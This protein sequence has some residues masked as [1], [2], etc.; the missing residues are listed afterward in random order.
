MALWVEN[1]CFLAKGLVKWGEG[2]VAMEIHR[3]VL[4]K[5]LTL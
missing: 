2:N 4:I 5:N 1:H 3:Q